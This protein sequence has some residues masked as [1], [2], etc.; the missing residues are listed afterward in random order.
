MRANRV[1][2]QNLWFPYMLW[3]IK[4][5][6]DFFSLF[7]QTIRWPH[8]VLAGVVSSLRPFFRESWLPPIY[9]HVLFW[10]LKFGP[11]RWLQFQ[12]TKFMVYHLKMRYR[13]WKALSWKTRWMICFW[14]IIHTLDESAVPVV[15]TINAWF[16]RLKTVPYWYGQN[17]IPFGK[18]LV[19][20]LVAYHV[21]DIFAKN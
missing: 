10:I 19:D 13:D 2:W 5:G 20:C 14:C 3:S 16:T 6:C 8:L 4:D 18:N 11:N 15:K 21:L 1:C 12:V 17:Q 7:F 9:R